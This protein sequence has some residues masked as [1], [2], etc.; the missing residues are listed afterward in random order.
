MDG[1][2]GVEALARILAGAADPPKDLKT[3]LTAQVLFW[4]LAAIDGHAKNFSLRLHA[5]HRYELTPLYDVLS[6]WPLVRQGTFAPQRVRLAMAI[7]G[8]SRHFHQQQIQRRHFNATARR[9]G[10]GADCEDLISELLQRV[11]PAIA[12]VQGLIP[13]GFPE[14]VAEAIFS[15]VRESAERLG[16][17]AGV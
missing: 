8:K 13:S 17:Q 6:A 11:E 14:D 10:W 12:R 2:P 16:S 9:C 1:G 7:S 15:G 3:L 5:G 4:M